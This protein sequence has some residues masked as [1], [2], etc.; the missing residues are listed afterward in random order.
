MYCNVLYC[1][2]LYCTVLYCTVPSCTVLY[3]TILCCSVPYCTVLCCIGTLCC[4]L[5]LLYFDELYCRTVILVSCA[6]ARPLLLTAVLQSCW[7]VVCAVHQSVPCVLL[8][9]PVPV[10]YCFHCTCVSYCFHC[11]RVY[12]TVSQP[13]SVLYCFLCP[14]VDHTD[15]SARV[16]TKLLSLPILVAHCFLCPCCHR[17]LPRRLAV[18]QQVGLHIHC[19]LAGGMVCA[20]R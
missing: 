1:T 8:S 2:V 17:S 15:D 9:L 20:C 3:R 16:C 4:A 13:M 10:L 19:R 11:P 18:R 12:L 14:H 6:F 5:I 7:S